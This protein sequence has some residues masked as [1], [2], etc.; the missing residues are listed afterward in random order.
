MNN[1][2]KEFLR[3]II[4]L[5][6]SLILVYVFVRLLLIIDHTNNIL[7]T[8]MCIPAGLFIGKFSYWLS[9]KVIIK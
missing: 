9:Y 5:T 3:P 7:F 6:L 4:G 2:L 8:L 1:N